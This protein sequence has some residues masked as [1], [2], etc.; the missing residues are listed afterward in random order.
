M[1]H[2]VHGVGSWRW[3][4]AL[5]HGDKRRL[6]FCFPRR[7]LVFTVPAGRS[8]IRAASS[9]ENPFWQQSKMA[10]RSSVFNRCKAASKSTRKAGSGADADASASISDAT[11]SSARSAASHSA[12]LRAAE[13]NSLQ[14]MPKSHVENRASPRYESRFFHAFKNVSCARSSARCPSPRVRRERKPRKGDWCR[15]TSS[16][17]AC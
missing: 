3:F 8:R 9:C 11:F 1:I 4:F 12:R 6:N 10:A 17:N 2:R 5:V 14:A 7:M 16:P 15:R 13:R